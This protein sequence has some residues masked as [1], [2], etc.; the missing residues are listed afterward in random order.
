MSLVKKIITGFLTLCFVF[1][2]ASVVQAGPLTNA[3]TNLQNAIGSTDLSPDLNSTVATI[4]K[5]VLALVGTIFFVLTVYAGV[6]WM[7]AQGNAEQV[8][9][10][11]A[12]VKTTIIGLAITMSAYAITVFVTGRLNP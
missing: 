11:T 5:G 10:A 7:T 2:C 6:I 1:A 12:I 4:I 8:E 9:R 3:Q